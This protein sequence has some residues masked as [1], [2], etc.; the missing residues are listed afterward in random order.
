MATPSSNGVVSLVQLTTFNEIDSLIIGTKWGGITGTGVNLTYSFGNTTFSHYDINS[1]N[2][3]TRYGNYDEPFTDT[4][5]PLTIEQQ[6]ATGNILDDWSEIAN[7]NFEE[8]VDSATVAGDIRFARTSVIPVE[9]AYIPSTTPE[10]GDIWLHYHEYFN[11]VTPG[12]EGYFR[13]AHEIGHAL[14]LAH[15]HDDIIA[16]P[17]FDQ[18]KY[19]VMSYNSF[20][21]QSSLVGSQTGYTQTFFPTTPMLHDIAAIQYIYG[22]NTST[23]NGNDVYSWQPGQQILETIWDGGGVDWID[24][25]NQSTAALINLNDGEWSQLGLPYSLDGVNPEY[26]TLAIAYNVT[27]ENARGGSGNDIIRGNEAANILRGGTGND[28]LT[29]SSGNDTLRGYGGVGEFD[30]LSGGLG[31]DT[32]ELGNASDVYYLGEGYATITDLSSSDRIILHGDVEQYTVRTANYNLGTITNDTMLFY[33]DEEI[34][35]FQ[36]TLDINI[37]DLEFV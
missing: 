17:E 35:L 29:G 8:V 1:S 33:Q 7:I 25:S 20:Q 4:Y 11:D 22:A 21:G 9:H 10:A 34:A 23:R 28:T 5:R 30:V 14:G 16:T 24:W 15:P 13:I 27:I 6:I 31:R 32:F 2:L 26:E 3:N 36:D 12:S 19:T 37:S 18:T